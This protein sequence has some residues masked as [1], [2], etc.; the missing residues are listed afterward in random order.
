MRQSGAMNATEDAN[1]DEVAVGALSDIYEAALLSN[2]LDVL[3]GMFLPDARVLRFGI[4]DQQRGHDELVAW[5]SQ[6]PGVPTSRR[7]TSRVVMAL[8]AD[9]VAVDLTFVNGDASAIGRQSQTWVRTPVGW[10][11]ARA[12]VSM[13]APPP[14]A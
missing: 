3:D 1:D 7:I 6:S 4:A 12:H 9:V 10:R 8:G 5:R 2:Q 13:Q 11:I 14:T